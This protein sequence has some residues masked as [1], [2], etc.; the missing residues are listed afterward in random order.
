MGEPVRPPVRGRPRASQR[1]LATRR[2][3]AFVLLLLGL[4]LVAWLAALG[5]GALRETEA[6]PPV[7]TA[8]PPPK[9]LRIV[10]PEGFT[11]REMAERVDAVNR[12]AKK[13]RNVT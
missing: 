8:P 9:P 7:T 1:Q 11:R 10:F 2:A 4:G 5:L 13:R 12:I 3:A 6:P